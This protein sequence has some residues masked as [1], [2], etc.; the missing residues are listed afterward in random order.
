MKFS[1]MK[2]QRVDLDYYKSLYKELEDGVY[3]ATSPAKLFELITQ[4]ENAYS[5]IMTMGTIA[6]IRHTIDTADKFY[7]KE[8]RFID[9]NMPLL[10]EYFLGFMRALLESP[11]RPE[12]ERKIG[13]LVFKNIEMELKCFSPKIVPLLQ[14]ENMLVSEYQTL[15]ASAQIDFDGRKLTT[16]QMVPYTINKD[17]SVRRSAYQALANFYKSIETRL[18]E[19][20][21]HLVKVRTRI[22][23]T[24]GYKSFTEVGYL[25][26]IR[27]CYTPEDIASYRKQVVEDIVP[28]VSRLKGKQAERIGIP[29]MKFYDDN[30]T[31][32]EGNPKPQG[33]SD[34]IFSAGKLMYSEMCPKTKEFI[35]FMFENELFDC[36]SK[37]GK[38]NGGYCTYIP[39]YK[40]P[41]IFSNF[42]GTSSD[43]DVFTHE[44]GHA[45][46]AYLT[47]N[48]ELSEQRSPTNDA[49]EVHSMSMEFFAWNWLKH[50]Y[51][52]DAERAKFAHLE[53]CLTF[54][55]YGTMVDHFQHIIYDKPEL[56][57][58]ERHDEWKK[59]EKIYRPYIDFEDIPFYNEGRLWQRQLHIYHYPFYY[60]DYCLAQ[61]VALKYW[62]MS[63]KNYKKAF[64]KYMSFVSYGGK[65]TFVDLCKKGGVMTP[66]EQG[67]LKEIARVAELW[68]ENY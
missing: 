31:Y 9:E 34:D 11:Y 30:F 17:R 3:R 12:I 39:D 35:E 44:A 19:L 8:N 5:Y 46:A 62:A 16:S 6:H 7:D 54:I 53:G 63:Q 40:S 29:D 36:L 23:K 27:N 21:D 10:Q 37:K 14:E 1:E 32:K 42:N 52:D 47:R 66:F 51:G 13:S 18:D 24:L 41:F 43:V 25:R 65:L 38:A 56:T 2:Y 67:S 68:L 48:F 22:A 61:T 64:D 28:I 33:S 4:H 20:Y 45:F 55:P 59:L 49:C 50:F 58:S 15:T 60:I 57:P 26:M